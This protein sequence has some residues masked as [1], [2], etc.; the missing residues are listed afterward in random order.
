MKSIKKDKNKKIFFSSI[1]KLELVLLFSVSFLC[2]SIFFSSA[3]YNQSNCSYSPIE[4]ISFSSSTIYIDG[5][6][7]F[8]NKA[9][10][11]SWPGS[12]T[13][14]DPFIISGLNI[15]TPENEIG[16]FIVNT[17]VYF[18]V[19][20]CTISGGKHSIKFSNLQNAKIVNV[21][22]SET[23]NAGILI[24]YCNKIVIE[25]CSIIQSSIGIYSVDCEDI[26]INDNKINDVSESGI[27]CHPAYYNKFEQI[28]EKAKIKEKIGN[29]GTR[30]LVSKV[31][32][33][34]VTNAGYNGIEVHTREGF[35][36]LV[37]GNYVQNAETGMFYAIQG[38]IKIYNNV[39]VDPIKDCF[40]LVD[41]NGETSIFN[42]TMSGAPDPFSALSFHEAK[43]L[44]IYNNFLFNNGID[45]GNE[46]G[47]GSAINLGSNCDNVTILDNLIV[48]N[49]IGI[50][51]FDTGDVAI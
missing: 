42:N 20:S 26:T 12:G 49:K 8:I 3:D 1:L 19:D 24:E 30:T 45:V 4:Q 50:S 48:D 14:G 18:I 37:E 9:E 38:L 11:E 28:D 36:A 2:C 21:V 25:K 10:N 44:L 16:I 31:S 35:Y 34:Y 39:I 7:D 29:R 22:A 40:V 51:L 13:S 47:C 46:K 5:D 43:N 23:E 15:S 33:N 6:V 41:S 32:N 27:V 17:E